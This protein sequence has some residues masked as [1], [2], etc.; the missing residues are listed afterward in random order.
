MLQ[1][2][3]FAVCGIQ[4]ALDSHPAQLFNVTDAGLLRQYRDA[5]IAALEAGDFETAL[6]KAL[7][8]QAMLAS[9]PQVNSQSN[10]NSMA[11]M[12]APEIEKFILNV[13]RQQAVAMG[14]RSSAIT[15]G[16]G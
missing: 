12:N 9:M 7:A 3:R 4:K 11:W 10:Q 14:L 1:N 2:R 6:R 15:Y 16:S 8:A 13:H 5:A